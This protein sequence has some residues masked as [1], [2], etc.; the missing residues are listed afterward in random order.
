MKESVE[1]ARHG[2]FYMVPQLFSS[3]S[4]FTTH[5]SSSKYQMKYGEYKLRGLI[6]NKVLLHQFSY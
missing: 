5:T 4:A 3:L 1:S 2:D 6:Y